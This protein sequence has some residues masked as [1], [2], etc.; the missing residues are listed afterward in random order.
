MDEVTICNMALSHLLISR[1]IESL[2]EGTQEADTC[3]LWY[4]RIR[5]Q[6]L[7]DYPW[8]F[9]ER[10][11][12]LALISEEPNTE[13]LYSYRVPTDFMGARRIAIAG[14]R[15]RTASIPFKVGSDAAGGTIFTDEPDATLVYTARIEN[16]A[17]FPEDFIQAVSLRLAYDIAKPISA[18]LTLA[19]QAMADYRSAVGQAQ[20]NS[21]NEQQPDDEP[22]AE[23]I[24]ARE[25]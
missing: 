1:Q 5:N 20:A 25:G 14:S 16:P 18:S 22:E 13:W 19:T 15:D 23:S 12:A 21:Q 4:T 2:T 10:Y 9:A 11:A 6:V 24:R 17:L 8:D 3:T 7:R